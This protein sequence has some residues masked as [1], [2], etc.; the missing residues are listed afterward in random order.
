MLDSLLDRLARQRG[1]GDAYHNY[2]GELLQIS[3]ETKTAILAAMGCSTTDRGGD[4]T[5]TARTRDGP[6]R[7]L[8]PP[9][10]VV[11]PHRNGVMLAVPAD[12]LE[13]ELDWRIVVAAATKF[14]VAHAPPTCRSTNGAKS[15]AAG[16]H[17]ATCR[18]PAI[19]RTGTTRCTSPS[20]AARA[21][22]AR[23][24][25]HRRRATSQRCCATAA[26]CG[27]WRCSSTRCA[28]STTGA[29]ATSP[30]L[31]R[32]AHVRGARRRVRRA[33]SAACA[34]PRQSVAVQPVQPVVA[35]FP[36]RAVHRGRA[37]AGVRVLRRGAGDRA[38][39]R[40]SRPSLRACARRPSV[41]YP[42]VA[43]AKLRCSSSC[44]RS[45]GA[46]RHCAPRRA[47]RSSVPT[48]PSVANR[49]GG[50]RCTTP[51]TAT[52]VRSMVTATGAG[53][54]GPR[55]C[56]IRRT[57]AWLRSRSCT[58]RRSS[59]TRG[60]SGWPTSNWAR[61]RRSVASSAWRSVST[62]TTRSA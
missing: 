39:R 18:C 46:T 11:H 22:P 36:E 54:C 51:S 47:P 34:V 20:K 2:R 29:S 59:S 55:S 28:R 45:S 6:L 21:K 24:S 52:C 37:R 40:S 7:S 26:G 19:C 10:A 48:S 58:R 44:T 62:A 13:R 57:P 60:C 17:G 5:R 23:S 42:G 43:H 14:A 30:T 56:A 25:W 15:T 50:M 41:D 32:R 16:R 49:C 35:A 8:L 33:Q 31:L 3:R 4:R 38:G 61:R 27:A 12:A 53:P 9:V 1:I